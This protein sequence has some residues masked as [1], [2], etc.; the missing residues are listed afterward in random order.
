MVGELAAVT[1]SGAAEDQ[2]GQDGCGPGPV[3]GVGGR[4]GGDEKGH[5]GRLDAG[6]PLG[7]QGQTGGKR[8][9]EVTFGQRAAPFCEAGATA[10]WKACAGATRLLCY[11]RSGREIIGPPATPATPAARP[12]G[13][14]ATARHRA[15]SLELRHEI[16]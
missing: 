5:G 1:S 7:Q 10:P 8:V 13:G 12:G 16:S 11:R 3:G 9:L 15:E 4:A 14:T 6:H 2:V